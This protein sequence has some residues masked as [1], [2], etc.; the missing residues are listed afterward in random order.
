MNQ[1]MIPLC[2][3]IVFGEEGE[4]SIIWRGHQLK[5]CPYLAVTPVLVGKTDGTY[6][7][8]HEFTITHLPSGRALDIVTSTDFS[9]IDA[10]AHELAT[11]TNWGLKS[12]LDIEDAFFTKHRIGLGVW[13]ID[14]VQ[15]LQDA[16]NN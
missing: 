10:L 9:L 6:K 2:I 4:Q 12:P 15:E 13:I 5:E 1:E 8:G 14:R 11:M 16:E 7:E 3:K